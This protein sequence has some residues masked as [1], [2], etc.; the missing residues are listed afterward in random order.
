LGIKELLQIAK[1]APVVTY[2]KRSIMIKLDIKKGDTILTGKFRNHKVVVK[3]IGT[4]EHG[5]PTVNGKGIMKIR[6]AKFEPEKKEVKE[7]E[8]L[9]DNILNEGDEF[10]G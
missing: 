3:T 2:I 5:L 4:D 9:V 8:S 6:I 10:N 7:S 1:Q